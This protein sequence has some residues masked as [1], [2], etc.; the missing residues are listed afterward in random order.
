MTTS[1]VVTEYCLFCGQ[2]KS[3]RYRT[4]LYC[5]ARHA[6]RQEKAIKRLRDTSPAEIQQE[7]SCEALRQA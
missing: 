2:L 7:V 5:C 3:A 6:E 1:V 4:S